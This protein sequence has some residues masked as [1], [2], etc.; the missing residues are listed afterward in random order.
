MCR[1]AWYVI[2]NNLKCSSNV[3]FVCRLSWYILCSMRASIAQFNNMDAKCVCTCSYSVYIWLDAMEQIVMMRMS[4]Y[5][6]HQ[7]NR[8][9]RF[10][11]SSP[12]SHLHSPHLPVD[13]SYTRR[14][15]IHNTASIITKRTGK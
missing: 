9:V 2:I 6:F 10:G 4:V 5:L 14:H 13:C 12:C 1:F 8:H 3:M 15:T 11:F 7:L